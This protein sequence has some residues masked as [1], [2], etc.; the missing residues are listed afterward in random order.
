MCGRFA[1]TQAKA[2]IIERFKV[3]KDCFPEFKTHY[4]IA[5][6]QNVP[7]I[8]KKDLRELHGMK[9]GLIPSWAKDPS[10]GSHM[11][12][13]RAETLTEKV[14]FKIPFKWRRC[15][16][17]SDG[18][19]E[20]KTEEEGKTPFLIQQKDLSLFAFAGMWAHWK[21]RGGD[22]IESCTI[23]TTDA[24]QW[25]RPIHAR[26]P[27]LLEPEGET[28]WLNPDAE[29]KD[30]LKLLKPCSENRLIAHP[31]SKKVN[32]PTNDYPELIDPFFDN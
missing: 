21:S 28:I 8:I 7:V 15:L 2:K 18:F 13:A 22:S 3:G 10:I 29:E 1:E 30:L 26:M 25:M 23:V 14:S 16:V 6:S 19:Y 31:V 5:P 32:N 27:V 9:W 11:I 4:N 20:W 12:N 17:V 24:N